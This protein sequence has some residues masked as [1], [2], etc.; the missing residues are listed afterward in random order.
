[1]EYIITPSQFKIL[2]EQ[3]IP[4][5]YQ[6]DGSSC[7]PTCIKMVGDFLVGGIGRIDDIC[8]SCGTDHIVGTPPDRMKKGLDELGLKYVEHQKEIEPFQSIKNTIDRGNVAIV[9]TV[10]EGVPHWVVIDEYDEESFGVNDP[11]LGPRR[12]TEEQLDSIW[13]IRDFFYFE[14]VGKNPQKVMNNVSIRQMRG[15]DIQELVRR[16]AEVFSKTGLSNEEIWDE[17]G[18]FN[19]KSIVAEVDGKL[20]GF[21]F[22]G[23]NQIPAGGQEYDVLK[24]LKGIEGIALGV[25]PEYKNL[26]VGNQMIEYTQNISG[27]DY[28][29]GM[30]FKSLKNIDDWLKRRKIYAETEWIY[31][32]YQIF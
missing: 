32:T 11:W 5:I 29:W 30:Q 25:F 20:G 16:F 13:R 14:M 26:G 12:Y 7:G 31:I 22:L 27:Y 10:T 23:D 28:I 8:K 15:D 21:Y 3:K 19:E 18:D 1:M 4:H 6:P 17:I 2:L 9:R 24:K